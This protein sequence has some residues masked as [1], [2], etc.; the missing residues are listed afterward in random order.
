[1]KRALPLFLLI[2]GIAVPVIAGLWIRFDDGQVWEKKKSF[3]FEGKPLFTSYDA[4]YFA[5]WS[6]EY[7]RGNYRPGEPYELRFVPDMTSYPDPIPME[8]WLAARLSSLFSL[9]IEWV[10][11]Y[12]T[13]VLAVLM[14]VPVYIFFHRLKLPLA[15]L[16]GALLGVISF[17]Y[18]IRTSICRFDTDSLNLFFP[19][20]IALA[21]HLSLKAGGRWRYF[22][23]VAAGILA[24]LYYWWYLHSGL[25]F[26][27]IPF[28]LAA[29]YFERELPFEEKK[30]LFLIFVISANP[31]ILLKG[32]YNLIGSI[33]SYLIN[34]FKPE[35]HGFPNVQKT[36]SELRRFELYKLAS[37]AAGNLF[38]FAVGL[39]G[40]ALL[41]LKRWR[42]LLLLLPILLIGLISFIGGNR[43]IMYLAPFIGIG[44]GY[45]LDS[46]YRL[47]EKGYILTVLAVFVVASILFSNRA[48]INFVATPKLTSALAGGFARLAS[49]TP[50]GSWVWSWWDFGTA[51]VYYSDRATY[52]DPQSFNTPKTYFVARS[53]VDP[54][55]E[56][57]YNSILG[58][59]NLGAEGIKEAIERGK[60]PAEI[61]EEIISGRYSKPLDRQ[62]Y[63]LFTGDT[64]NKF[65]AI[66]SLGNW[67]FQAQRGRPFVF[68]TGNC[69]KRGVKFFC[70]FGEISPKMP[71]L[72]TKE[73]KLVPLSLSLE[74]A[75][76]GRILFL[77]KGGKGGRLVFEAVKLSKNFYIGFVMDRGAYR[78]NFNRMF[79]LRKFD[80]EFFELVYDS[81][82]GVVLYRV[83]QH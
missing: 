25:I 19:F 37:W 46:L 3:F 38:L 12:L 59:S 41:L 1:L 64:L 11:F 26:V 67:N 18:L 81:F 83:K 9:P 69:V 65:V 80:P 70:T 49:L 27:F 79:I 51:I 73:K 4:F 60:S 20:S 56:V 55:S 62:I 44:F 6:K 16:G 13:P 28:Y 29:L 24:Q 23:A 72:L 58:V 66:S 17:S 34:F 21:L 82:P 7:L 30:K 75:K 57:A 33:K 8:S 10:A 2:F 54:S 63:W 42:E 35:L 15:G 71:A 50:Q 31:L 76:D 45:L 47:K 74:L 40:L 53:M 14:V 68:M 39:A 77:K 52:H 32:V 48:S 36:V 43:F 5:I 22:W 78:S 61:T